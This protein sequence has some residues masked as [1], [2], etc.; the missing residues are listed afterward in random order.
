[1]ILQEA[2]G[3]ELLRMCSCWEIAELA[4]YMAD[5]LQGAD[6]LSA[7][8]ASHALGDDRIVRLMMERVMPS[9]MPVILDDQTGSAEYMV[10]QYLGRAGASLACMV[11]KYITEE[12]WQR[13]GKMQQGHSFAFQVVNRWW[14]NNAASKSGLAVGAIEDQHVDDNLQEMLSLVRLELVQTKVLEKW[15]GD[16]TRMMPGGQ[17]E[18]EWAFV[19]NKVE[20]ILMKVVSIDQ[21][22][23][24]LVVAFVQDTACEAGAASA[25]L[26]GADACCR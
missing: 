18:E 12:N 20:E 3:E 4:E 10:L 24:V 15:K 14:E 21:C 2:D 17:G 16:L 1:M 22:L 6:Q 19:S 26:L 9:C 11:L 5:R 25:G 23:C 8:A 13:K 7:L